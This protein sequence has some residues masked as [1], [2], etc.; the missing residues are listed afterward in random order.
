[1]RDDGNLDARALVE[2]VFTVRDQAWRG[3]GTLP[4]SGLALRPAYAV[5]D[6]ALRFGLVDVVA[7]PDGRCRAGEVLTGRLR[8]NACEAFG[9]ACTPAS[10]LGAPMVSAEGACAAWFAAGRARA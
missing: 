8:P 9:T 1:V 4:A 10:P 6:A 2:R 5:H 7:A 3:L